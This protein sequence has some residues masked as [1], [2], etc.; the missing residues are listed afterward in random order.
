MT[1]I[2]ISIAK[3][4][5][6]KFD[7]KKN[8]MSSF[9][10][11]LIRSTEVIHSNKTVTETIAVMFFIQGISSKSK[12]NL[13]TNNKLSTLAECREFALEKDLRY[14]KK[15]FFN[16]GKDMKTNQTNFRMYED[17]KSKNRL[18]YNKTIPKN[19]P[20]LTETNSDYVFKTTRI[21]FK[22]WENRGFKKAN[23]ETSAFFRRMEGYI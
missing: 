15:S 22:E 7:S 18:I 12:E 6:T 14:D 8:A 23:N 17:S 19:E 1:S 21:Y 20:T 11:E 3:T 5:R 2:S 9:L 16:E 13:I 4:Y 10:E